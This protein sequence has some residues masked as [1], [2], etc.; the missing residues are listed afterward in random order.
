MA[1]YDKLYDLW[2]ESSLKNRVTVAVVIAAQAVQNEDSATA[3]HAARLL[4]S[5]QAFE[6]PVAAANPIYRVILAV[7][8]DLDQEA[9]LGASDSNIQAAVDD[10]VNTF[11]TG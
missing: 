1:D 10:A 7:N 9:I 6:N 3:N 5:R 8:R 2:Y 11:A 4:W